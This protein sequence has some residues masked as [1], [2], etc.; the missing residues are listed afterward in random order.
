MIDENRG[1]DEEILGTVEK[2]KE[3][4]KLFIPITEWE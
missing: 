2:E 4:N 3:N 1:K